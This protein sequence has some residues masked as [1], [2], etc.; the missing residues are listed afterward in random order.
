VTLPI[1]VNGDVF[2]SSTDRKTAPWAR[3]RKSKG[4]NGAEPLANSFGLPAGPD[5]SCRGATKWCWPGTCYADAIAAWLPSVRA[6]MAHNWDVYQRNKGSAT[7]LTKALL[8]ML[9]KFHADCAKR[10]VDPVFRWFWDGD[11]P[12]RRFAAAMRKVA[13]RYCDVQFWVY[14]RNFDA[15]S[16]LWPSPNLTVYLSVDRYNWREAH[17]CWERNPR[18]R[19]AFCADTW[20]ETQELAAR[21]DDER[22]GPRCPELT[23]KIPLVV[24]GDGGTGR[25]ACVECGMCITGIN[26]VRFASQ[27]G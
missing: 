17:R 8:P 24:W 21:F 22:R 23:G 4:S 15:V 14:T 27:K 13:L 6:L 5:Y 12:G 16:A 11:I 20:D 9:A 7:A 3:P 19:L 10:G 18:V 25:G 2:R 1:I 26:N